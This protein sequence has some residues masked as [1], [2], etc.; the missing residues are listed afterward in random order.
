MTAKHLAIVFVAVAGLPF[1]AQ[2]QSQQRVAVSAEEIAQTLSAQ[3][4]RIADDQV[5]LL[6]NVVATESHPQLDILSVAPFGGRTS[7]KHAEAQSLVKLGCRRPGT[8]LPF[9]V[10]VKE[11][12]GNSVSGAP[13][14]P[15]ALLK[16][17]AGKNLAI[18]MRSGTHAVLQMDDNRSHVQIAVISLQDGSAGDRIRVASPDRKQIFTAEVIGA[19][20][21]KRSY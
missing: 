19:N 18:T 4:I 1:G 7:T 20:L 5:S 16:L 15:V 2:G 14:T 13:G 9:Y 10:V 21:L 6:A 11:D 17:R 8:C 12:E 3:G